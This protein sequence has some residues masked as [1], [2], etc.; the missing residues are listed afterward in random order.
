[1]G[2]KPQEE[3][4]VLQRHQIDALGL[5][6]FSH[7]KSKAGAFNHI[8]TKWEATGLK[9]VSQCRALRPI[10]LWGLREQQVQV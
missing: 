10:E 5:Y 4:V 2:L 6:A 3:L 7:A 9:A 1:M 8:H